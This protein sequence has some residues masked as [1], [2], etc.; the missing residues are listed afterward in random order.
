MHEYV[1]GG[2]QETITIAQ[3][4]AQTVIEESAQGPRIVALEGEL[5]AGK[6]TFVQAF[7]AALGVAEKLKSPTFTIFKK[8]KIDAGPFASLYH[9]DCYRLKDSNDLKALGIQ[10]I[11]CQPDA[12]ILIE[13]AERVADILPAKRTTIHIDHVAEQKRRITIS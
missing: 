4:Y 10:E 9:I 1:S 8:Y 7:A 13:W 5:G 11:L 2:V 3:T 12:I 6:T